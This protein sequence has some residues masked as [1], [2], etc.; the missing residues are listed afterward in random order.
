MGTRRS[1]VERAGLSFDEKERLFL[2]VATH[3]KCPVG[4]ADPTKLKKYPIK[5]FLNL[6]EFIGYV[7]DLEDAMHEDAKV[8]A[9]V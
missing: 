3:P 7:S 8:D 9:D 2:S 6:L 4:L 5:D 1:A